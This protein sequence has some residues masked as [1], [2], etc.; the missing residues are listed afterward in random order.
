[1]SLNTKK[2]FLLLLL[3][4]VALPLIHA[5]SDVAEIQKT[6]EAETT[7][8]HVNADR[9]VFL[10]YWHITDATIMVYSP[11]NGKSTVLTGPMMKGAAQAGQIPLADQ[12]QAEFSSY[13]IRA[14]GNVGWASFDQ[15]ET[16]ANGT[17]T[18]LYGFRCLEKIDGKWKIVSSSVHSY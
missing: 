14:S 7:A 3:F 18:H 5:Q 10:S 8:F 13:V 15:K 12:G 16:A 6:I 11:I 2:T 4:V 9:N 17:I 1:M